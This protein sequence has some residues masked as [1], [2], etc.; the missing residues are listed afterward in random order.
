MVYDEDAA[1]LLMI[2]A[3]CSNSWAELNQKS[4][5]CLM[6]RDSITPPFLTP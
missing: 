3:D 6:N 4:C 5:S 2:L 1:R